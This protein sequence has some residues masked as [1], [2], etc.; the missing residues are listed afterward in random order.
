[1]L[2]VLPLSSMTALA[3]N[4]DSNP[5]AEDITFTLTSVATLEEGEYWETETSFHLRGVVTEEAVEGDLTGTGIITMDGNF[6]EADGC[7]EE[8]CPGYIDSS[9][10]LTI[11]DES[12]TW[13]GNM[14]FTIDEVEGTEVGKVMLIGRGGNAGKALYGDMVFLPN[15]ESSAQVTGQVVTLNAPSQGIRFFYDGCFVPPAGTAGG[16]LVSGGSWNDSGSWNADYPLLIPGG[17][18]FGESTV[19]TANGTIDSVLMLQTSGTNRIGHFMVLGGTGEY[20]NL[21]GF[22]VVRTSA[23]QTDRCEGNPGAGGHWIGRAYAN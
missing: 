18:T 10:T 8:A 7:T 12:G 16:V 11:T 13:D 3:Q 6:V 17:A 2:L 22:G 4:G 9:S 5:H 21:Y 19:T 23:F 15:E 1:M 14:A 20:E